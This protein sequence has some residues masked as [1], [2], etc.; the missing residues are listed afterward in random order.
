MRIAK[1]IL[2][3]VGLIWIFFPS[4]LHA[5]SMPASKTQTGT[6]LSAY[7]LSVEKGDGKRIVLSLADI[8]KIKRLTIKANDHGKEATFEGYPLFE[9]LKLAGIEFGEKLRGKRLAS[10]L[11][12][13][14]ADKYQVVF[15]LPEIDPAFTDKIIILA[16]KRDGQPLSKAEGDLRLVV[17]DEKRGGRWVRQVIGFKILRAGS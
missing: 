5:Q 8:A 11:L 12:V 4:A 2:M 6:P 3:I 9:V 17:P 16:D 1:N 7:S 10:F 13:E 14:A 15:A